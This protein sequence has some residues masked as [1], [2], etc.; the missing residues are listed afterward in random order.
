MLMLNR[1]IGQS[2]WIGNEIRVTVVDIYEPITR[3][4]VV[5]PPEIPI[6]RKELYR[7]LLA[8]GEET[9]SFAGMNLKQKHT[10][11]PDRAPMLI[12]T[13]RV[14]ESILIGDSI[15]VTLL[16]YEKMN[17]VSIGINAPND[18][19]ILREERTQQERSWKSTGS[20]KQDIGLYQRHL[21]VLGRNEETEIIPNV[22]LRIA[23][24]GQQ[25]ASLS[26]T[27]PRRVRIRRGEQSNEQNA[28][29]H[30]GARVQPDKMGTVVIS[31]RAGENISIDNDAIVILQE[32]NDKGVCLEIY[33][34]DR[35]SHYGPKPR[36]LMGR[37]RDKYAK[38]DSDTENG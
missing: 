33:T 27:A 8:S 35:A 31:R 3:L 23:A 9:Q 32:V 25:D 15:D 19:P 30:G 17:A 2:I 22:R 38:N 36:N 11:N 13:R 26:V 12:L 16:R 5:A 10:G 20:K 24:I 1:K 29:Q 14:G 4:G 18:I 37:N 7:R 6:F 21:I 34:N 28:S